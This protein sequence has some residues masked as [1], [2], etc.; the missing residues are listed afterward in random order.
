[1]QGEACR[2]HRGKWEVRNLKPWQRT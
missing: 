2:L 1:M